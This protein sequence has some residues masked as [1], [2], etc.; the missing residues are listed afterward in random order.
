MPG[1]P[2]TLT[3]PERLLGRP[4]LYERTAEP[5]WDDPHIATHM[6]SVHLDPTTDAASRKPE[7]IDRSVDWIASLPLPEAASL[8]DLGC[9]PGLYA[10]RFTAHG[11]TVT[12]LDISANSLDY[13][14]SHDPA[15]RYLHQSYLDMEFDG[16]FD[17]AIMIWCDYGALIPQERQT[18]LRRVRKAL[19]PTGL[20]VFDAFTPRQQSPETT[21]WQLNLD[22]GFWCAEPHFVLDATYTYS[23]IAECRRTVVI[24]DHDTHQ[25]TIWNCLLTADRRREELAASGFTS[26]QLYSDAAGTRFN[27]NS[28]TGGTPCFGP[29]GV[30]VLVSS[31]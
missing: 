27:E 1:R 28:Q 29:V 30:R 17:I 7:S 18:L 21:S 11:L 20:F 9:G 3:D 19:K 2:F 15:S 24:T 25:Y 22:G 14:R 13:A 16:I 6:L 10:S 23:D 5:F 8:L 31:S 4:G 26:P 12:G